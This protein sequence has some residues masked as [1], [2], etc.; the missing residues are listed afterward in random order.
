MSPEWIGKHVFFCHLAATIYATVIAAL[1]QPTVQ[2]QNLT[3]P[4][5]EYAA[6]PEGTTVMKD[7]QIRLA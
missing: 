5:S 4:H 3:W 6:A 7:T 2:H 1:M